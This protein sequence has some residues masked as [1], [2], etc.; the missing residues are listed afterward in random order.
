MRRAFIAILL[1][2]LGFTCAAN[3]ASAPVSAVIATDVYAISGIRVD[4]T[5]SSPRAARELAMAQGRPVAWRELFRRFNAQ[6]MVGSQPQLADKQLLGMILSYEVDHEQHSTTRY[7]AD[8]V[9]HFNPAA[10]RQVLRTSN[11]AFAEARSEPALVIPIIAGQPGFDPKSAWAIAWANPSL[12][13]SLVLVVL[14]GDIADLPMPV[15]LIELDWAALAPMARRYNAR[16]VI[17]AIASED[18][19]TVQMIEVSATGRSSFAFTQSTLAADAKAIAE[20]AA[21]EWTLSIDRPSVEREPD[22]IVDDGAPTRLTA[23]V[24][25]DTMKDWATLRTRLGA[26]KSLSDIEIIGL[27]LHDAQID[28]TY[29]GQMEKLQ[30]TLTRQNL[31]LGGNRGHYTLELDT[32]T[33]TNAP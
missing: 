18:A 7:V 20:K 6:G 33:P 27:A 25:F 26:M 9:F 21:T 16:Q 3:G 32:A 23:N 8:V 11:I 29:S 19:K 5:A 13:Q 15:N 28:L 10:V 30:D 22:S 4:A 17:I 2:T 31:K 12:Q 1:T 24:R 14:K